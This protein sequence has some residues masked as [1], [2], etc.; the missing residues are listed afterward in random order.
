MLRGMRTSGSRTTRRRR[1]RSC[2]PRPAVT[3]RSRA[4]PRRGPRTR[5]RRD[6][7]RERAGRVRVRRARPDPARGRPGRPHLLALPRRRRPR[8]A[9]APRRGRRDSGNGAPGVADHAYASGGEREQADR[10]PRDRRGQGRS[11]RARIRGTP[12]PTCAGL[13]RGGRRDRP[14]RP[15]G[16]SPA[17]T[18]WAPDRG[19]TASAFPPIAEYGFLSDC[20]TCALVAPNGSVEW[21]CLPRFDSPSVF[22]AILDRDA[23]YFRLGPADVEVPAARRYLPGTNVLETSWGTSGGW[24][25]V[26]DVL[27]IGPWHHDKDRSRTHRRA[28]PRHD[29]PPPPLRR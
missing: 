14:A 20:E 29:A 27:L 7:V 17:M 5:A 28:P 15:R 4:A 8:R 13:A 12:R 22:G 18:E 23:G 24:I 19:V 10:L 6:R 16:G 2:S 3:W 11:G 21:L 1:R 25:I 26:R 9:R